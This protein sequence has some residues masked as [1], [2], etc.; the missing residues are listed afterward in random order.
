VSGKW[1]VY[2]LQK[3]WPPFYSTLKEDRKKDLE[4]NKQ[5][6]LVPN[7]CKFW[8]N[9][10]IY[11]LKIAKIPTFYSIGPKR[12]PQVQHRMSV[13]QRIS[14]YLGFISREPVGF[15]LYKKARAR[16]SSDANNL[17]SGMNIFRDRK[18]K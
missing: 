5:F 8:L 1:Y 18:T 14:Q 2:S 9:F 6:L 4:Q 17:E 16:P 11:K 3:K 12:S 7:L 15:S 13:V 10:L